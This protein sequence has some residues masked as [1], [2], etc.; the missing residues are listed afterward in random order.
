MRK[1]RAKE[2][3]LPLG[4][5]NVV[6]ALPERSLTDEIRDAG[7]SLDLTTIKDIIFVRALRWLRTRSPGRSDHALRGWLGKLCRDYGEEITLHAL[8]RAQQTSPVEVVAFVEGCCRKLKRTGGIA[9]GID[10]A[11]PLSIAGIN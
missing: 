8:R 11:D 3:P 9:G 7:D 4:N 5:P 1:S 10:Q 6:V 2:P